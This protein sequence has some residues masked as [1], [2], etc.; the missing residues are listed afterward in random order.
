M[1]LNKKNLYV[2]RLQVSLWKVLFGIKESRMDID[3]SA[4]NANFQCSKIAQDCFCECL[5]CKHETLSSNSSSNLKKKKGVMQENSTSGIQV[6]P[7]YGDSGTYLGHK[8][9]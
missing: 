9:G 7:V 3:S 5:L 4:I 8:L 2:I 1:I 6:H